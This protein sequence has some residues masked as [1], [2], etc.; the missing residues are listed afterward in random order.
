M[1][2]CP[3]AMI[4]LRLEH[5]DNEADSAQLSLGFDLFGLAQAPLRCTRALKPDRPQVLKPN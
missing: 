1:L 5:L 4:F 2:E 3:I